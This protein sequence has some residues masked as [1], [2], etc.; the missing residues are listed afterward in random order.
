MGFVL[1]ARAEGSRDQGFAGDVPWPCLGERLRQ[2]EK[3]RPARH[4]NPESAGTQAA[5]AGI[6]YQCARAHQRFDFI[7]AKRLLAAWSEASSGWTLEGRA[8][9]RD[10]GLE[11]GHARERSGRFPA[12]QCRA[13][14]GCLQRT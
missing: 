9:P 4:R 10:L 13:R 6:D 1:A 11:C 5:A 3:H 7:E 12:R 14:S 8:R 2:L